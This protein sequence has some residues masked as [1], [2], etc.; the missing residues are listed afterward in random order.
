MLYCDSPCQSTFEVVIT[1]RVIGIL[2][3][4]PGEPVRR[5]VV[6]VWG[7]TGDIEHRQIAD[8]LLG[9]RIVTHGRD[10]DLRAAC[11]ELGN[12]PPPLSATVAPTC[13]PEAASIDNTWAVLVA[14]RSAEVA[15]RRTQV[16]PSALNCPTVADDRDG[17]PDPGPPCGC[18]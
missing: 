13:L 1:A 11:D 3:S 5:M 12:G 6:P 17:G 4:R 15:G 16:V 18:R 9:G 10:R 7:A 8:R 2:V 14:G